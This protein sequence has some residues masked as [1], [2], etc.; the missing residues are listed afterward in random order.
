[1]E[2]L[3][4]DEGRDYAKKSTPPYGKWFFYERI[5]KVPL[6]AIFNPKE[7]ALEV[8]HLKS[9]HYQHQK[10]DKNERYW[11]E[12]L[13]LFLGVWY[14]SKPDSNRT[15]YWL[16][17]WDTDGNLLLWGFEKNQQVETTT[18]LRIAKQMLQANIAIAIIM[19]VTGL[20]KASIEDLQK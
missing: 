20:D 3:S 15:G 14:G 10:P 12:A 7:G 6:Y 19:Q 9:N 5:L 4:D 18:T 1:M 2:F 8:Y 17:W 16:R 11:I 13:D